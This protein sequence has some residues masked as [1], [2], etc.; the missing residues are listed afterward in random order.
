MAANDS[1]A[2]NGLHKAEGKV[3]GAV[4]TAGLCRDTHRTGVGPPGG[5]M[6]STLASHVL[7]SAIFWEATKLRSARFYWRN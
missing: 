7:P 6:T 2:P 3:R 1:P 4:S 5:V